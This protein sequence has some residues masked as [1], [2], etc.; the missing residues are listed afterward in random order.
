MS[1]PTA[2]V[3][4]MTTTAERLERLLTLKHN[5]DPVAQ[6]DYADELNTATVLWTTRPGDTDRIA[7]ILDTL[8]TRITPHEATGGRHNAQTSPIRLPVPT[9]GP[10]RLTQARTE[11]P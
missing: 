4:T 5:P 2:N 9:A 6:L 3:G 10:Q 7:N 11:T 1:D 8:L